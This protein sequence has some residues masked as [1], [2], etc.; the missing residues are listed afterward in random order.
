MSFSSEWLALREPA[1]HR[2]RDLALAGRLAT[3]LAPVAVPRIVD[4]GC[5]TGSNLRALA[6]LLG[7]KQDWTLVDYDPEL[8][9]ASRDRLTRWADEAR[10]DDGALVLTK[11]EKEIRVHFAQTDLSRGLAALLNSATDLVTAAALFDLCSADFIAKAAREIADSGAAFYTVLTYDGDEQWFPP[12]AADD[13]VLGAFVAHQK[14]DKGF[15]LSAGPDATQFLSDAFSAAGYAVHEASTPW[16]LEAPRDSALMG[17]LSEGIANAAAETGRVD[18]A[19]IDA[20]RTARADATRASIG[21]R[22]LLA[23]PKT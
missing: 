20:W 7:P 3:H 1:D 17:A 5:G 19:S 12:H 6:P 14:T 22:D 8:L 21:H 13:A 11:N 10:N 23:L 15:G 16:L 4:L 18:P 2:A 9:A